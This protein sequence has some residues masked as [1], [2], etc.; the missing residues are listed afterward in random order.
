MQNEL[1]CFQQ[2]CAHKLNTITDN[3]DDIPVEHVRNVTQHAICSLE[4][5]SNGNNVVIIDTAKD[6]TELTKIKGIV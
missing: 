4:L 6:V 3:M 2:T 1:V 5:T